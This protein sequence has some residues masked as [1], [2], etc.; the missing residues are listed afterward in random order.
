[1]QGFVLYSSNRVE[2]EIQFEGWITDRPDSIFYGLEILKSLMLS[3]EQLNELI[4]SKLKA[5]RKK[6]KQRKKELK[7]F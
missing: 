7:L 3:V 1:M 6:E 5:K 2:K 4:V